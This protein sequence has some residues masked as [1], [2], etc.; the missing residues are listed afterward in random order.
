MYSK[1]NVYF[2]NCKILNNIALRLDRDFFEIKVGL[3]V[4]ILDS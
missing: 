2:L 3:S 4:V 1:L